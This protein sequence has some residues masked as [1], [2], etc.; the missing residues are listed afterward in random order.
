MDPSFYESRTATATNSSVASATADTGA[1]LG[2]YTFKISKLASDASW[3]GVPAAAN[4]LSATDSLA[5]VT[6]ADAGFANP[7]TAGTFTVNGTQITIA[8]TDTL[9]SV[10]EQINSV[11]G[12]TASYSPTTDE[13]TLSS[14]SPLVLGNANDTSNFLQD[15]QLYNAAQ[16]D[17]NG[18]YSITSASALGGINLD[19]VL[20]SSNLATPINDGGGG[21]GQFLINGVA[22]DFN[23]STDTINSVLQKINESAAGVTATFDASNNEFQLTNTSTG[24]VGIT[25]QDVTGNFLAATGLAGGALQ[26]GTNLQYSINGGG[27]LTSQ[28]N[29]IDSTSSGLTGLTVT[30]LAVGSAAITVASD[31][32]TI[33]TAINSFVTDYNAAQKYISSQTASTTSSDGTV[34]AGTLTG[35]MNV[36]GMATELR[37]LTDA[38][39]P[40]MTGSVQD[41]NSIG[42]ASNGTDNTLAV[43]S[44]SLNAALAGNL[45]AI[46]Q[47][48]TDPAHGL[49]V[50]LNK[51]LT[52]T[53]NPSGVH[54]TQEASFSTQST[55]IGTSITNLQNQ[56]TQSETNLQNEFVAM[57]EAISSINTQKEYLTDFFNDPVST[58]A[59]PT[60]A[61]TSA[62]SSSGSSSA[63]SS[64]STS[65]SSAAG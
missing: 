62:E 35:D 55:D 15:A 60:T 2:A 21:N 24:D 33:A 34:T 36:E 5:G 7:V 54:A 8:S 14:S 44:A 40:H 16:V 3:Q 38:A 27:T 42:V 43:D 11:Q 1:P 51:Y 53:T 49:A 4:P 56:I 17:T 31:T 32:A 6:V 65:S 47:L 64:G 39:P 46:Q 52:T 26:R 45:D 37:E 18:T 25:L 13:I 48:F 50:T 23:A 9:Q 59:A 30:A 28:S 12:V 19:N 57:E 29:T 58:N 10:L 41:L 22:I 20:S 63:S 61:D